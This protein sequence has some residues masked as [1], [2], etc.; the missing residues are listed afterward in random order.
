MHSFCI[1]SHLCKGI[2][3]SDP[4]WGC[5]VFPRLLIFFPTFLGTSCQTKELQ[6]IIISEC[7]FKN[8][9]ATFVKSYHFLLCL[10]LS[11]GQF[12]RHILLKSVSLLIFFIFPYF[13]ENV[14][15]LSQLNG[16]RIEMD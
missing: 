2:R 7:F 3:Y 12:V 4:F 13:E 5:S 8:V 10:F 6:V 15:F 16:F 14:K 1:Q 11:V 9:V